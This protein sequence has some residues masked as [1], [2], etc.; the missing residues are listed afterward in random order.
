MIYFIH[1]ERLGLKFLPKSLNLSGSTEKPHDGSKTC[2]LSI[3]K[4]RRWKFLDVHFFLG[5]QELGFQRCGGFLTCSWEIPQ[6]GIESRKKT[7]KHTKVQ[8]RWKRGQPNSH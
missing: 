3:A 6:L 5:H 4:E 8:E 7:Q 2:N 1:P